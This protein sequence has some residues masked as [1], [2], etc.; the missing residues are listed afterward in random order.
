MDPAKSTTI[1]V[2]EDDANDSFL[3]IRQLE[4]AQID[5]HVTVIDN[6]QNALTFLHEAT[7][8]PLAIFLDLRLP[9]LTGLDLLK[10]IR[11]DSRLQSV[12]VIIM[13]GTSDPNDVRECER[14]GIT[15]FMEKPI[16][17]TSFIKTVAHLFP[18]ATSSE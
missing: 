13:S 6:G 17:L 11:E 2:V 1:L 9:G 16:S 18:K 10:K 3:L 5:D 4:K 14:L 8:L 7:E 12:P 15:A